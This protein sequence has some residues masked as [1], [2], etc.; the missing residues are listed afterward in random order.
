MLQHCTF[1]R[2]T[3]FSQENFVFP[4]F[5]EAHYDGKIR[6]GWGGK[7]DYLAVCVT[8]KGLSKEKL[9][10]DV[11][12]GKGTGRNMATATMQLL[13]EW[14]LAKLQPPTVIGICFDTTTTMTGWQSGGHEIIYS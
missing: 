14:G 12:I 10:G 1:T 13:R 4:R 9:L 11:P 2:R 6:E 7:S 3:L 5:V 8:G